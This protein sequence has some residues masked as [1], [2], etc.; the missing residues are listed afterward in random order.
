MTYQ[1]LRRVLSGGP[2]RNTQDASLSFVGNQAEQS[3]GVG[4]LLSQCQL[5]ITEHA[6]VRHASL[7]AS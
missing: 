1:N 3:G 2:L 6:G 4:I 5:A 7:N